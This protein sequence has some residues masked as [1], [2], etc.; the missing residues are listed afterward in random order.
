MDYHNNAIGRKIWN[1]DTTYKKF[2]GFTVGLRNPS[3]NRLKEL[4]YQQIEKA[5][6]IYKNES[7]KSTENKKKELERI[8]WLIK[9]TNKNTSV[10]YSVNN[11]DYYGY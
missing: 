1:D 10:Y 4:V 6:Y 11:S 7:Y 3:N 5:R 2:W 8:Y 9:K